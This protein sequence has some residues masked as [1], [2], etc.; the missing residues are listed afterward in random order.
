MKVTPKVIDYAIHGIFLRHLVGVGSSLPLKTLAQDWQEAGLRKPDLGK[1]LEAL[2]KTGRLALEQTTDGMVVRLLN[3]DFGLAVSLDDWT[4]A[5]TLT[6]LRAA[7]RRPMSHIAALAPKNP[8]DR[9][10]KPKT[11]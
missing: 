4:A 8:T 2:R 6:K 7:R 1:G 5:D 11:P 3:E 10:T 9:R